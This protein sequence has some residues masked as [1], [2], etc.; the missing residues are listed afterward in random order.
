V[1]V[2]NLLDKKYFANADNNTNISPGYPRTIRIA[3]TTAF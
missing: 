3:L 1:N 2:E